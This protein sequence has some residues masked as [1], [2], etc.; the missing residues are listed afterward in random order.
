MSHWAIVFSW[1]LAALDHIPVTIYCI[2]IHTHVNLINQ[3]EYSNSDPLTEYWRPKRVPE[4]SNTNSNLTPYNAHLNLAVLTY[5]KNNQCCE[6][7][8]VMCCGDNSKVFSL[9]PGTKEGRLHFT[10]R[11]WLWVSKVSHPCSLLWT[12]A[13]W[14]KIGE[15]CRK[16]CKKQQQQ[17]YI[18]YGTC[19]V[20]TGLVATRQ[21]VAA[22]AL[23]L[24][25]RGLLFNCYCTVAVCVCVLCATG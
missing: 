9:E 16:R 11:S 18:Q 24:W 2:F 12:P 10:G 22:T 17:P 21:Y 14:L 5:F 15:K 6:S 20:V 7:F 3:C 1:V 25:L 4:Y 8:Q 19:L 13:A 23:V